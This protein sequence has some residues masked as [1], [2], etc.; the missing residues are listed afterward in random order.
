[1]VVE[2]P[3]CRYDE[4]GDHSIHSS[5]PLRVQ[6]ADGNF[7]IEGEGF[8]WQQTNSSLFISNHVHTF[9]HPDLLRPPGPNARTNQPAAGTNGVEIFSDQFDYAGDAGVGNYRRNV[10][11]KGAELD[12]SAATLQFLLPMKQRQLQ[13]LTAEGNVV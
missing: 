11:V 2:A 4:A 8:R 1:M 12:L 6:A 9:V 3:Q 13:R 7:S 10:R 5:G